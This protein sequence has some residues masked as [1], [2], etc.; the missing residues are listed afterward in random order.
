MIVVSHRGPF[1]F[2]RAPDGSFVTRRGAGGVVGALGPLLAGGDH[3]ATGAGNPPVW[4]AAAIGEDERDAVEAGAVDVA[5]VDLRLLVLDERTHHLHYDLVS[6]GTLWFLYHDLFDLARRP[7]FDRRWREA[8]DAYVEVNAT[9]ADAV[10]DAAEPGDV[11]LVQ[12]YQLALVPGRLRELRPDLRVVHFTH[13]PFCGPDV[14]GVLPFDVAEMLCASMASVPHGF[15]AQRWAS[16]FRASCERVLG[17][18]PPTTFVAPLGPDADELAEVAASAEAVAARE[19]LDALVGDRVLLLRTD[20]IEPSKNI[21]RGFAAYELLLEDHPSWRGRVVFVAMLYAS[22]EGLSEYQAYRTEVEAAAARVNA[23]FG[24]ADWQPVVLDTRDDFARTVAGLQRADVLLVNPLRD[25]LNLVAKEGPLLNERDAVLCLS[26][27]AG[28]WD[29]LQSAVCTVH[30]FDL[31]QTAA[32]LHRALTMPVAERGEQATRLR[33]L[34]AA[35][36]SA[37]WLADLMAAA[38][39]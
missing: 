8:W 21:V 39:A 26:P 7:R 27:G 4:V 5:G 31:E 13:T 16:A 9:F 36:T 14:I 1:S 10:L 18:P 28:A 32:E 19:A 6:N 12:D 37:M 23:R 29:E 25:G 20:R 22:R 34:V 15:H 3:S 24:T 38:E 33:D 30:P 35:R 2:S 11:V 17:G